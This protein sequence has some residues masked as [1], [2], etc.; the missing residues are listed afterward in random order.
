M[1]HLV[2][3]MEEEARTL[4]AQAG[5]EVQAH[6]PF[7]VVALDAKIAF[8]SLKREAI[9]LFFQTHLGGAGDSVEQRLAWALLWKYVEAHYSVEGWL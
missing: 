6:G 8:N 1:F 2:A 4:N 9:W 5:P 3:A 7:V